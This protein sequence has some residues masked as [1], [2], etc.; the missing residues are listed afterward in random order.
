[1]N[2][3]DS[4]YGCSVD[5]HDDDGNI[6]DDDDEEAATRW[7]VWER[8]SRESGWGGCDVCERARI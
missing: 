1:M 7:S 8:G 4:R 6:E 3:P 2:Q 5:D